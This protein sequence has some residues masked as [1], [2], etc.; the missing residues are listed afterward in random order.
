MHGPAEVDFADKMFSAVETVLGLKQY[1]VKLGIMDEERRTSVNIKECIRA[2]KKRVAFINTGFLDR[3]G[4]E[5]HTSMEAGPFSRKD[6]IKRKSWI[7]GYENQ[8]VDIGLECGLSG[9]AQIGKGMWAMP[10][11]MSA[12]LEQKIEHPKSGANC[13][14]P[15]PTAATL[16]AL[17]YH[18][19]DVFAVQENLRKT[20][21]EPMLI[22]FDIP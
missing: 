20:A 17:H 12:M 8:N 5:I 3:T 21:E 18:Q 6:F 9:R 2:A 19:V 22:R 1:S 7:V 11:L 4:D 16:H 15:S 10:D 13:P 14:A